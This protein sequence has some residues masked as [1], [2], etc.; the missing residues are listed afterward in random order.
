MQIYAFFLEQNLQLKKSYVQ[1]LP[2]NKIK[3]N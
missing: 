1:R 2:L 3:S